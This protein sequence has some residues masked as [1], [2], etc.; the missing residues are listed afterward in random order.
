MLSLTVLGNA[1]GRTGDITVDESVAGIFNVF[2]KADL[3]QTGK[4]VN[5]KGEP[6]PF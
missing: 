3:S 6:L 5:W 4:F 1:G 2:T